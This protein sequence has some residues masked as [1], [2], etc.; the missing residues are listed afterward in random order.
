MECVR[1]THSA[2]LRL[3][4]CRAALSDPGNAFHN[5]GFGAVL[6]G[7]TQCHVFCVTRV[8][9]GALSRVPG[10]EGA[11]Q[12]GGSEWNVGP[13]GPDGGH[14]PGDTGTLGQGGGV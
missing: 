4:P 5:G 3:G 12:F 14:G 11:V 6:H 1:Q 9:I 2:A 7:A 13:T 10:V 8:L